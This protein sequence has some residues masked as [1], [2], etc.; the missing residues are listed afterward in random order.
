MRA[1]IW[2]ATVSICYATG[3]VNG[4]LMTD[5]PGEATLEYKHDFEHLCATR[6]V[7]VKAHHADNGRFAERS[8]IND[9]KRCF[10]RINF[11]DVS[12]HHQN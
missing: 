12:A 9:M 4:S 1:R 2:A 10:Q 8:F 3:C 7:K 5:K 6:G 11:C